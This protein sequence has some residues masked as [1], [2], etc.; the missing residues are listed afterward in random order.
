MI[1][2]LNGSESKESV[3]FCLLSVPKRFARIIYGEAVKS[4][5]RDLYG[6]VL[7]KIRLGSSLFLIISFQLLSLIGVCCVAS[8]KVSYLIADRTR[9]T[10]V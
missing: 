6:E 9:G 3:D 5:L 8:Y 1:R 10:F 4:W 7:R 2:L